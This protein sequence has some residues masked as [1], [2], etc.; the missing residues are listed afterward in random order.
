[1]TDS[2]GNQFFQETD[3]S[4]YQANCTDSV[5]AV[6][7]VQKVDSGGNPLST[8]RDY[9]YLDSSGSNLTTWP[10]A[11]IDTRGTCTGY[12]RNDFTNNPWRVD[13]VIVA[14]A[15]TTI[16]TTNSRVDSPL[17]APGLQSNTP[18]TRRPTLPPACRDR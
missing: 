6:T 5:G 2:T 13:A 4:Y 8:E 9:Y 12:Q 18:T 7:S 16:P 14:S 11:R 10:I 17:S 3:Y 1:M 15:P